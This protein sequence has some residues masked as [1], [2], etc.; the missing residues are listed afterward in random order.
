MHSIRKQDKE[1]WYVIRLEHN[2]EGQTEYCDLFHGLS[3]HTAIS[4]CS[5]LNGGELKID[6]KILQMCS[7]E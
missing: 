3:L 2:S 5:A 6:V 4:I 1:Q 7:M